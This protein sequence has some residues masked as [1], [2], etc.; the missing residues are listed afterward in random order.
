MIQMDEKVQKLL[1][2]IQTKYHTDEEALKKQ[3]EKRISELEK[4]YEK[5]IQTETIEIYL[6]EQ[7]TVRT[8]EKKGFRESEMFY[9]KEKLK[10]INTFIERLMAEIKEKIINSNFEKKRNIYLLL[11]NQ[12]LLL[13]KDVY[14]ISC[15]KD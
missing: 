8:I 9:N 13:T 15:S 6:N 10:L 4:K 14:T 2:L 3:Y 1:N 7:E 11:F 5:D 12:A